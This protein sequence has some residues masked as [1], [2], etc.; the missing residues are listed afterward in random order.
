M[1][2]FHKVHHAFQNRCPERIGF[3]FPC[4]HDEPHRFTVERFAHLLVEPESRT[5]AADA[6]ISQLLAVI[7]ETQPH[8]VG[9]CEKRLGNG[10]AAHHLGT[11]LDAC[12]QR[13]REAVLLGKEQGFLLHGHARVH[14]AEDRQ[15]LAAVA[16]DAPLDGVLPIRYDELT[17]A[18]TDL[19]L[20]CHIFIDVYNT[21]KRL[22]YHTAYKIM[23]D[24]Y[25]A[26][27]VLQE[28]FLYV[29]KNFSKIHRENCHEL[30]AYLVSCS[31]SRAYDMLRKQREEPLEEVPDAP[32]DAPVPDDAAVSTDNIQ[33][34]TELI[35]QMKPMY[36]D[37]LRLLAM[38]YT[39]REIAES[40]G[41][42][43]EVVR[44]RLFR[45]RKLLWKELNSRE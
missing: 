33:H 40:L 1:V 28:V 16:E 27:D 22:V 15:I 4:C 42:T 35:G 26:E 13:R 6:V 11:E 9:G 24:S 12:R 21:Y 38:G 30:A 31:R 8:P 3:A 29:A 19:R 23:G 41:L 43:D 32:D 10:I 25:L 44:M 18:E 34:L 45:G 20:I 39:N 14:L 7:I 37:P 17:V 36:R 5:N 2:Q